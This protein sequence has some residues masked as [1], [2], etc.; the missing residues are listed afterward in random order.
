MSVLQLLLDGTGFPPD[1]ISVAGYG[2]YHPVADNGTAEGRRSN[3]RV[4]L[5]VVAARG[6][7]E[8]LH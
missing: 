1:K 4:D 7:E 2:P 6:K 8:G 3:R 5:V